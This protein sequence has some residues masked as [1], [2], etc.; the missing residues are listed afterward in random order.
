MIFIPGNVP[1][2]KNSKQIA[3]VGGRPTLLYS[4]TVKKY[5][6]NLGIQRFSSTSGIVGYKTR[7][8]VFKSTLDG[9]FENAPTPCV[10][11]MN[12]VR[13]SLR[14]FDV[15]NAMQIIADLIVAHG[16]LPDDDVKNLIPVPMKINGS[17][18]SIC[19]SSPGVYLKI[20]KDYNIS[21]D[22]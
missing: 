13:D 9:F 12:F 16:F 8:N 21:V 19:R 1:S 20:I 11:G 3:V 10:L 5:L 6:Q 7:Q 22:I 4:K 14:T 17:F 18:Y 2:S 15:I